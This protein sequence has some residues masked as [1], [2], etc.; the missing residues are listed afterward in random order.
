MTEL[1]LD[2]IKNIHFVGIGGISMSGLAE[3]LRLKGYNI[4]GSDFKESELIS[5]LRGLGILVC[6]GHEC[7]N[8]PKDCELLVYT[9]AIK[10]NNPELL[11]A[12]EMGI[13]IVDRAEL[14]GA[15]MDLY[16]YSIGVAGTHGKT[17]TTSMISEILLDGGYDPSLNVGGIFTSIG[18]NFRSGKSEYFV[19]ESCEYFDSFSKF[20]PYVG[21][22]LNIERD[23]TDYFKTMEQLENS[24]HRF[25]SNIKENGA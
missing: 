22:I 8:V 17:T 13:K 10:P 2:K 20:Y 3:M 14:L 12:M 19:A 21:V 6:I 1:S 23:H 5:H 18:S 15:I 16:E 9:A 25:A 24:F 11:T 4:T 7:E